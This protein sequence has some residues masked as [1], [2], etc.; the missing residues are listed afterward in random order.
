MK[1]F[2][3][4]ILFLII[5]E[6]EFATTPPITMNTIALFIKRAEEYQNEQFIVDAFASNNIGQVSQVH[7][8]PKNMDTSTKPYN[9]VVV[10]FQR[11]N[12]NPLVQTLID[13]MLQSRDGT[14]RFYFNPTRYWVINIH[15]QT[16]P[17]P[18]PP[19]RPITCDQDQVKDPNQVKDKDRNQDNDLQLQSM[20]AQL[21]YV[22][23]INHANVDKIKDLD[24]KHTHLTLLNQELNSQ[25]D[26]K[27]WD[28]QIQQDILKQEI[29]R[30]REDNNRLRQMLSSTP[31]VN[32]Q[33][34]YNSPGWGWRPDQDQDQE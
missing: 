28:N 11:F 23:Q 3:H 18:S 15:K 34:R 19:P 1:F 32:Q 20:A 14:T 7:F 27:D 8:I 12:M 24:L 26:E 29:Q 30:L 33:T 9:G 17:T 6:R 5:R 22:T 4:I 31:A 2:K 16:P 13:A 10:Q 21:Y 25:L